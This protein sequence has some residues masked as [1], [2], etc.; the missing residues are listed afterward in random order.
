MKSNESQLSVEKLR[1]I[2]KEELII[3]NE[4]VDHA[5]IVNIVQ[6][7]SKLLAAVEAFKEKASPAAINAVTPHLSVLEKTLEDM[8][9]SPGSYVMKPKLEPKR[10]SLK[11]I[12]ASKP[13]E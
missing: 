11:A 8:V 6:G 5:S 3:V 12:K 13:A 4:Q 10:V 2:I 1:N 9:S 7:A